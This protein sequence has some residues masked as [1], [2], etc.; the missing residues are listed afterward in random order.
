MLKKKHLLVYPRMGATCYSLLATLKSFHSTITNK[1]YFLVFTLF[2]NNKG[3]IDAINHLSDG[4]V[5]PYN[6]VT[7]KFDREDDL[8]KLF[9]KWAEENTISLDDTE[10]DKEEIE[11]AVEVEIKPEL[12]DNKCIELHCHSKQS[13][14]NKIDALSQSHFKILELL[15]Q[16]VELTK[17]AN[18]TPEMLQTQE[19]IKVLSQAVKQ[20]SFDF[21]ELKTKFEENTKSNNATNSGNNTAITNS[22]SITSNGTSSGT[23]TTTTSTS[24]TPSTASTGTSTTSNSS[25]SSTTQETI[26]IKIPSL[27]SPTLNIK[28]PFE[29]KPLEVE[30][31]GSFKYINGVF[32]IIGSQWNSGFRSTVPIENPGDYFQYKLSG[33]GIIG[34][35][36]FPKASTNWKGTDWANYHTSATAIRQF[37]NDAYTS[38]AIAIEVEQTMRFAIDKDK[39]LLWQS[40]DK[41]GIVKELFKSANPMSSGV[42]L[43]CTPALNTKVFDL[44]IG[45]SS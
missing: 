15:Q 7:K 31:F 34:V 40:V 4:R 11:V 35:T 21:G 19:I 37:V 12:N 8:V 42:F 28:P 1:D 27:V 45:K 9:Y 22:Q 29:G 36:P 14:E 17:E 26:T 13:L 43:F 30:L 39:Y 18:D 32:E 38:S 2:R 41:E 6:P 44:K 33:I 5:L 3:V 24:T 20:L 10:P 16:N 23:G 25:T